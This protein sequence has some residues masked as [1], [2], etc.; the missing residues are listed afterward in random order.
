M[1]DLVRVTGLILKSEPVSDYDRRI[2]ILT[3]ER[4]KITAFAK[5][6][7]RPN[8]RYVAVTSP[9]SFGELRLIEGRNAYNLMEADIKNYFEELRTDFE[10]AYYGIYFCDIADYYGRENNDERELLK[11]LYMS[12]KALTK[13]SIPHKLVRYIYELKAIMVNGEFPGLPLDRLYN[14][15]TLYAVQFI[16]QTPVEHLFT[17]NVNEYVL[18]ELAWI[19][20]KT[21]KRCIDRTLKS[22]EI[23]ESIC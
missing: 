1:Q 21:R 12:L 2:V 17:F 23:L 9:F 22:L 10:G 19:A 5:G 14:D 18:S 7:R 15:S 4:G 3:R 13:D 11:L 8:S 16:E 20:E 6:A